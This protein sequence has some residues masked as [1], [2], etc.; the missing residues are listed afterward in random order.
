MNKED[1]RQIVSILEQVFACKIHASCPENTDF[2][3]D[4]MDPTPGIDVVKNL[5]ANQHMLTSENVNR[6]IVERLRLPPEV[7][8]IDSFRVYEAELADAVSAVKYRVA[9]NYEYHKLLPTQQV[10]FALNDACVRFTGS[11]SHFYY[12]YIKMCEI[13][14][15]V[16]YKYSEL[17]RCIAEDKMLSIIDMHHRN[18]MSELY[19]QNI[20]DPYVQQGGVLAH[21]RSDIDATSV[22]NLFFYKHAK[23]LLYYQL[24]KNLIVTTKQ[25]ADYGQLPQH[26]REELWQKLQSAFPAF[27]TEDDNNIFYKFIK[28]INQRP[29]ELYNSFSEELKEFSALP[30]EQMHMTLQYAGLES[31]QLVLVSRTFVEN[32]HPK[33]FLSLS[34]QRKY[35]LV[36]ITAIEQVV[37]RKAD[38]V[39]QI[40][41][42]P[43][44]LPYFPGHGLSICGNG[45]VEGYQEYGTAE[46]E[47]N[48][49]R[50][51]TAEI[52]NIPRDIEKL[53]R[54]MQLF[55]SEKDPVSIFQ[56]AISYSS[57]QATQHCHIIKGDISCWPIYLLPESDVYNLCD[58]K[59]EFVIV[60]TKQDA[61]YLR[62][63][64]NNLDN[65]Q[66]I[67][68][69][70]DMNN[71]LHEYYKGYEYLD[72]EMH[73]FRQDNQYVFIYE[74]HARL[75]L[76]QNGR[77]YNPDIDQQTNR[78]PQ[79]FV[80]NDLDVP[81]CTDSAKHGRQYL[82]DYFDKTYKSQMH[83]VMQQFFANLL[84]RR[85]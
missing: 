74:P 26:Q 78:K 52:T 82:R 2:H 14:N 4:F 47:W 58:A 30:A 3:L 65:E 24:A 38:S 84:N 73:I 63:V 50:D 64:F 40:R 69:L 9:A 71:Y 8:M 59:F 31:N 53:F 34:W 57:I 29:G 79:Y 1:Y 33:R 46:Y 25:V 37:V 15:I 23:L 41:I 18:E 36:L 39:E 42:W 51:P 35:P 83:R 56:N 22:S 45:L 6:L 7:K 49:P 13:A 60:G 27:S 44:E 80:P 62:V 12:H 77:F 48:M 54:E 81:I 11:S 20:L 70:I 72:T 76:L 66:L 10:L 5:I 19:L 55:D 43:N 68:T 21:G 85:A 32:W 28:Y 16:R 75:L 67:E 61:L 17:N